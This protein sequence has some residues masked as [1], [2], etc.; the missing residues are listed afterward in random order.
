MTDAE[1]RLW[2]AL[3]DRG[4]AGW[5]FRRQVPIQGY[6]VDFACLPA[7]LVV[8]LDGGQHEPTR[9][10]ARTRVL[11]AAGYRVVRFW[12]HEAL[13][14]TDGVLAAI[15]RHLAEGTSAARP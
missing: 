7:Q 5:K 14:N 4:I 1:T 8:E 15:A 13:A 12:N 9:D 2:A 10:D 11:E 6:V 3:R